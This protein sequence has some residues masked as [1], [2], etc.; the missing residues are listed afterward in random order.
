MYWV[1]ALVIVLGGCA[2]SE[3]PPAH[4]LVG[5]WRGNQTLTLTVAEYSYGSERGHWS[6]DR[7]SF[8]YV[9][10]DDT[11]AMGRTYERCSFSII[12]RALILTECRMAGRFTRMQ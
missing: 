5:T 8:R 4:P 2:T 3:G 11:P 12:G 1:L 6:A 10:A 9:T 7:S